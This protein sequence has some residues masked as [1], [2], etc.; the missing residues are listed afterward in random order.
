[1]KATP[2]QPSTDA[3]ITL[4]N[5]P[6][7]V[8]T[9]IKDPYH[10]VRRAI[11]LELLEQALHGFTPK[12]PVLEIG[13]AQESMLRGF[14]TDGRL[15]INADI[16]HSP[17][18]TYDRNGHLIMHLDATKPLP[19]KDSSITAIITGEFIEHPFNV[20]EI[21]EEFQRV[22]VPD[23]ILIVTT[24]NLAAVQDRARFMFGNSPRHVNALHPY[25]FVH[26]RPFTAKSLRRILAATGF[27]RL[28]LKSNF[29]GW[30]LP[31][32]KWLQSRTLARLLPTLG[33]SL[34]VS[35]RK[36]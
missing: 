2:T 34:V 12:E 4:Y 11:A 30:E 26:I 24:P 22:L 13:G 16:I 7:V 1:M 33:G 6:K 28:V 19:F 35:A 5:D 36:R 14:K 15:I 31:S 25:L 20:K 3:N 27:E 23:G 18:K 32:G 8:S 29:V 10:I 21:L 9:Y 17:M